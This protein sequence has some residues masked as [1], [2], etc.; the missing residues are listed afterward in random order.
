RG[1][2][3]LIGRLGAIEAIGGSSQLP[4]RPASHPALRRHDRA[5]LTAP[6][7]S[8]SARCTSQ[9]FAAYSSIAVITAQPPH[10]DERRPCPEQIR[11][12]DVEPRFRRHS[13]WL[14]RCRRT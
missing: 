3:F 12:S 6:G 1:L 10:R 9:V 8:P 5:C 4:N 11:L 2:G 14:T 7:R 13:L